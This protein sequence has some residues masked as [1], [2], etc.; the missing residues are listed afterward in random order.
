MII[1]NDKQI[2]IEPVKNENDKYFLE[3]CF[4]SKE[5]RLFINKTPTTSCYKLL[6]YKE[7]YVGC[8]ADNYTYNYGVHSCTPIIYVDNKRYSVVCILQMFKY[9]FETYTID[10]VSFAVFGHNTPCLLL[11]KKMQIHCDGEMKYYTYC[12]EQYV[13]CFIFSILPEEYE[14]I[15]VK[16]NNLFS[17]Y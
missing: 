17:G 3:K 12:N 9:I 4:K 13:S 11:F 10:K 2:S 15:R 6:K 14:L 5:F 8:F 7:Q 1:V 16:I